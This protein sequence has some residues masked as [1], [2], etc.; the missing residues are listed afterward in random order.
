[1]ISHNYKNQSL[2][3]TCHLFI[4]DINTNSHEF[5]IVLSLEKIGTN[6]CIQLIRTTPWPTGVVQGNKKGVGLSN[7]APGWFKKDR[8]SLD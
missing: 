1:M 2:K 5:L 8:K 4:K 6:Y 7:P 3:T